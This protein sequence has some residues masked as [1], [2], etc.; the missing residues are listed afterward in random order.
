MQAFNDLVSDIV[1]G[2]LDPMLTDT[3]HARTA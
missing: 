1:A 2:T 3:S